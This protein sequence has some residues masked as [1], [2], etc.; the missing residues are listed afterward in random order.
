MRQEASTGELKSDLWNPGQ[1]ISFS[2]PRIQALVHEVKPQW[3]D[4]GYKNH[5]W[6]TEWKLWAFIVV[7]QHLV[8]LTCIH[9]MIGV[10][11]QLK[12]KEVADK[13]T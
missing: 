9:V 8:A 5:C 10:T 4:Q 11:L 12:K 6:I 7:V 3:W 13:V 2:G 1:L